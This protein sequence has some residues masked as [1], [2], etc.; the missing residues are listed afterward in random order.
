MK[1][2][3]KILAFIALLVLYLSV[4]GAPGWPTLYGR[5]LFVIY[6]FGAVLALW[7]GSQRIGTL[8]PISLRPIFVALGVFVMAAAFVIMLT[9]R[10]TAKSLQEIHGSAPNQ[11]VG[12]K[13]S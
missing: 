7:I 8:D 1:T 10:D 5:K 13:I 4:S 9:T 3:L 2:T 12:C 11:R 6:V